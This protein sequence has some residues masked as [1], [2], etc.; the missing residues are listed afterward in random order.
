MKISKTL[1]F[2][3]TGLWLLILA[4]FS[5]FTT[6]SASTNLI[7]YTTGQ[8]FLIA[9]LIPYLNESKKNRASKCLK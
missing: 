4:Y 2:G 7:I 3:A 8:G 5:F 1:L 9:L 6:T